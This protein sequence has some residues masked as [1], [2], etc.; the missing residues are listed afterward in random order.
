MWA[1][2]GASGLRIRSNVLRMRM[3][4]P[5]GQEDEEMALWAFGRDQGHVLYMRGAEHLRDGNDQLREVTERFP[6]TNLSRYIH[7]C[8]GYSQAREFKDVVQ[9][10]TR[11][12]EPEKAIQELERARAFS[13]RWD[14]H[15]SL[16]NI[17]HGRT[18]DL[19]SG[20]YRQTNQPKQAKS[21]L[22]Q[23]ARY[24]TR[25]QVK[26]EVIEDMRAR[27]RSIGEEY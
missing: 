5:Q 6:K 13:P 3:A 24:F 26:P 16:D 20:L 22:T 14:G 25:M 7:Y 17:T 1:V 12:P 10:R 11:Q 21:V 4:F 23:T 18:V 19:L 15:S 27:A 2:Y 8:F 9:G